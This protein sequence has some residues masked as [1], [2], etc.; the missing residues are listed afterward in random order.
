[1]VRS[2][3]ARCAAL[4]VPRH[5]ALSCL[6]RR[7]RIAAVGKRPGLLNL[8]D[9]YFASP[10]QAR[11]DGVLLLYGRLC[12]TFCDVHHFSTSYP[13]AF[14]V[15]RKIGWKWVLGADSQSG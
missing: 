11:V 8:L 14:V 1:M 2:V 6:S 3:D 7:R 5:A 13:V 9:F 12:S 10:K 4:Y 15:A